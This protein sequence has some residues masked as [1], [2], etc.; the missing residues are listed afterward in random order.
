MRDERQKEQLDE[1][2]KNVFAGYAT[3]VLAVVCFVLFLAVL[4]FIVRL[5]VGAGSGV[6]V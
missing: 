2:A 1:T 6:S 4:T 3:V 5:I